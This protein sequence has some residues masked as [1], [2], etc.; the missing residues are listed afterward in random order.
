MVRKRFFRSLYN[1]DCFTNEEIR[2]YVR[3][4]VGPG[5][6]ALVRRHLL[7]CTYCR[8]AYRIIAASHEDPD[9]VGGTERRKIAAR[10][11]DR[12][13]RRAEAGWRRTAPPE[14]PA[15]LEAGQVWSTKAKPYYPLVEPGQVVV[16][17]S[18]PVLIV[19]PGA[20]DQSRENMVRVAPISYDA[21]Y[22]VNGEDLVVGEEQS[23]LGCEIMI[24]V[25]NEQPAIA[26]NLLR[27]LGDLD[28]TR[29]RSMS[30][31]RAEYFA[32]ALEGGD[33]QAAPATSADP[34]I[35]EYRRREIEETRY[36]REPAEQMIRAGRTSRIKKKG[37]GIIHVDVPPMIRRLAAAEASALYEVSCS[38]GPDEADSDFD[39]YLFFEEEGL[40]CYVLLEKDAFHL[41]VYCTVPDEIEWIRVQGRK[42]RVRIEYR[43][44]V[45]LIGAHKNI[46]GKSVRLAFSRRGRRYDFIL[47]FRD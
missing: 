20:G 17:V 7:E 2:G 13:S 11:I 47:R 23:P 28:P 41:A 34:E 29:L 30:R 14:R 9:E 42:R 21:E 35:I 8:E 44:A 38:Y 45:A 18:R 16:N 15:R 37:E 3:D 36:L 39:E 26:F 25:W 31:T 5:R 40:E 43:K 24:E 32:R 4:E 1:K 27:L 19:D 12:L 22:A 46:A 6:S 33:A 10:E